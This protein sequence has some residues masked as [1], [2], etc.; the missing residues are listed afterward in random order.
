[1]A[2]TQWLAAPQQCAGQFGQQVGAAGRRG[3]FIGEGEPLRQGGQAGGEHESPRTSRAGRDE[4]RKYCLL[5]HSLRPRYKARWPRVQLVQRPHPALLQRQHAI[6][7]RGDLVQLLLQLLQPLLNLKVGAQPLQG[8]GKREG[9][10][11][12]GQVRRG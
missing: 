10:P 9:M 1:M 11:G 4:G 3:W 7:V 12:E 2:G 5:F 6:G 8:A